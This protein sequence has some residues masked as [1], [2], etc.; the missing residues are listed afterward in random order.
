MPSSQL[1]GRRD[2]AVLK[3]REKKKKGQGNKEGLVKGTRDKRTAKEED[4]R[5]R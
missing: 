2:A 5:R 3:H 4:D 1:V